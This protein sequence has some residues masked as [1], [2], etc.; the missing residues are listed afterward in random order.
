MTREERVI[1][2]LINV[3]SQFQASLDEVDVDEDCR[4]A[5]ED[6]EEIVNAL[7]MATKALEQEPCKDAVSR[8]AVKEQMIKYGFHASDMTVTEFVEDLPPVLPKREYGEWISIQPGILNDSAMCSK[9]KE[10]TMMRCEFHYKFCPK[11]GADMRLN[12]VK[13]V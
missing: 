7:E 11:C 6:N 12:E 8:Q 13:N 10:R 2:V 9:C 5:K 1:K 3:Q 4:E